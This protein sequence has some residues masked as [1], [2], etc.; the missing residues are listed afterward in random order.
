MLHTHA[1]DGFTW[2]NVRIWKN[3]RLKDVRAEYEIAALAVI[4]PLR[5]FAR[6]GACRSAEVSVKA[7]ETKRCA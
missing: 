6:V 7:A 3:S 5:A 4:R 2:K 1:G